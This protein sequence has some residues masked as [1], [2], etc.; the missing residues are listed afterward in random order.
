M[1]KRARI[2]RPR[3]DGP[4]VPAASR[5][6]GSRVSVRR[7]SLSALAAGA[8]V[9]LIAIATLVVIGLLGVSAMTPIASPTRPVAPEGEVADVARALVDPG[10]LV[11]DAARDREQVVG[12]LVGR[13]E[14]SRGEAERTVADWEKIYSASDPA[15]AA[16]ERHSVEPSEQVSGAP[17]WVAIWAVVGFLAAAAALAM[18]GRSRRGGNRYSTA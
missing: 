17:T 3:W 4:K 14:M 16:V 6:A 1:A 8:V 13:A 18:A 11:T 10:P 15:L 7:Y 5:L 2:D 12:A 9:G